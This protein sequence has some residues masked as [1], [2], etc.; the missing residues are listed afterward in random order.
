MLMAREVER[1]PAEQPM[2]VARLTIELL[3]P[4]GRIPLT[5][6]SRMVRPGRRVQLIEASLGRVALCCASN[7]IPPGLDHVEGAVRGDA[8]RLVP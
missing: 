6:R 2:F 8:L 1:T 3:R 7:P 5:V 4:V